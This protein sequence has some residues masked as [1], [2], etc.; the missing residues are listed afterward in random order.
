MHRIF[1]EMGG[2]Q[3]AWFGVMMVLAFLAGLVSWNLLGRREGRDIDFCSDLLLWVMVGGIVGGRVAYVASDFRHF[4]AQPAQILLLNQG[5]LI[6]YGGFI[7]AGVAI[8]LFARRRREKLLPLLDFIITSVPLGHVFGR[9]GCFLNGCCYGARYDGLLS[10]RYPADNPF[11]P[12]GFSVHPVQIYEAAANLLLYGLLL[13]AYRRRPRAGQVLALYLTTYPV[14]RF[15][16]ELLRGD[17]RELWGLT[18]AQDVSVALF[19][20]GVGFW[21]GSWRGK[22]TVPAPSPTTKS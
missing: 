11:A 7:G 10:V 20:I 15:L 18:V 17:E 3:I 8:V 5:G 9:I 2:F 19:V 13:W 22:P 6:Y 21:I 14:I 4:I 16:M 12:A 1:L